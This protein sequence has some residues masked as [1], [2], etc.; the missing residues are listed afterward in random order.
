MEKHTD[1]AALDRAL[2]DLYRTDIPTG[3]RAA[4]RDA[5]KREEKQTMMKQT[6]RRTLRRALLPVAAALVLVVGAI[7]AGNLIP[8]FT[9]YNAEY[10]MMPAQQAS[11][12]SADGGNGWAMDGARYYAALP[13]AEAPMTT[14][15]PALEA[16]YA[17]SASAPLP[18]NKA[19][20]AQGA[21]DE[22]AAQDTAGD[23]LVRTADLTLA[24]TNYDADV[25]AVKQLTLSMGGY[26][27]SVS[28]SGEPSAR[29]DRTAYLSLRVP[30]DRLDGFLTG[31]AA[32]GRTVSRY[33][34]ATDMGTQYADTAMRLATQRDKLARLTELLAQAADVS[35]LLEIET[36]IADT[37]YQIDALESALRTIDR[38]VS[39][40][41]VSVTLLEQS[42]G[43][44]AQATE[45]TLW[46]RI[47]GGF[48]ASMRE[49]SAFGQNVLVFLAMALPVLL[50]L[51]ALAAAFLLLRRAWRITHPKAET[52]GTALPDG[53]PAQTAANPQG[54]EAD[55]AASPADD[56]PADGQ[57]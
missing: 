24:T 17:M 45:L 14:S 30:S 31:L 7:A 2:T 19:F 4:W 20:V 6:G 46:Q 1:P 23:K 53:K 40:S 29:M 37:Q 3:Y 48:E 50:P 39:K 26:L 56:P 12:N 13:E 43:D 21:T 25:E 51:A 54:A 22:G 55:P 5:V 52:A 15:A 47:A 9:Y 49:L 41:A 36:Q 34:S 44:T 42:A 11:T 8:T 32:I 16:D 35:D 27:A 38:D 57:A 18:Q 10:A 28:Q 33:E